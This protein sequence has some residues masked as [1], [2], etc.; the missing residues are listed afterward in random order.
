MGHGGRRAGAGRPKHRTVLDVALSLSA[1]AEWEASPPVYRDTGDGGVAVAYRPSA[2]S[3]KRSSIPAAAIRL[4]EIEEKAGHARRS[5]SEIEAELVEKTHAQTANDTTLTGY[6]HKKGV[7]P[8]EDDENASWDESGLDTIFK[9]R[10]SGSSMSDFLMEDFY[11]GS[12]QPGELRG[13]K[14]IR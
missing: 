13:L 7:P 11:D 9:P 3:A 6:R 14:W 12:K 5:L 8:T 1:P 10:G 2:A 4:Q